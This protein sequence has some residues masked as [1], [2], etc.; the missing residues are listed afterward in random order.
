MCRPST[1]RWLAVALINFGLLAHLYLYTS[2]N[3]PDQLT[4]PL[5]VQAAVFACLVA[6]P[7]FEINKWTIHH[8]RLD[9]VDGPQSIQDQKANHDL[10]FKPIMEPPPTS[11]GVAQNTDQDHCYG[12]ITQD[13]T[14]KQWVKRIL[15]TTH[16]SRFSRR[17]ANQKRPT[18][19]LKSLLLREHPLNRNLNRRITV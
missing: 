8:N 2:A 13:N 3:L 9:K 6:L 18:L 7:P 16:A 14:A 5:L 15:N 17:V 11:T 1:P 19:S 4:I 12:L 10:P